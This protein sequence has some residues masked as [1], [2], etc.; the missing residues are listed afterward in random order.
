MRREC[1]LNHF[2]L[3]LE[4]LNNEL[5]LVGQLQVGSEEAYEVLISLYQA[6]VYGL[7]YRILGDPAEA[8]DA[9][10]E[11]FV[12]IFKGIKKFRGECGLKTWIYKVTISESLNR[13]RWWKRWKK[14]EPVSIDE[15]LDS[16]G[17]ESRRPREIE[18]LTQC[19]EAAFS[20]REI[21]SAVHEALKEIAVE[22]RI[23]VILR[24]MEGL[25]YEEIADT[26][27]VSL[28]TVKSRL[29]RGRMELKKAIQPFLSNQSGY[30][31]VR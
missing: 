25:S 28:G 19:P 13:R 29:W 6:P 10:Q 15:P 17:Y 24:D 9:A 22:Y 7:A 20:R 11:T 12:K 2:E 21:E 8:A 31:E 27:R 16:D 30:N 1:A 14:H 18:D 4:F 23:A 26:L 3:S 5:A